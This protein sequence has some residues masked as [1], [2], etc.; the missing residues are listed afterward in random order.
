MDFE[1]NGPFFLTRAKGIIDSSAAAKKQFWQDIE[2]QHTGLPDACGCFVFAIKA[3]RGTL[4][5][6]VGK[7][8]RLS[9][10]QECLSPHKVTHF[11]RAVAGRTSSAPVIYLLPHLT[12][13]GKYK[14]PATAK[15]DHQAVQ[16]LESLL[17]GMAFSKNPDL[18]NIKGTKWLRELMVKGF[19]NSKKAKGGPAKELRA[20]FGI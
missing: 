12:A 5:W 9:F 18:L 14:S 13:G 6:Y 1:V 17:I 3:N 20:V 8:E 16:K 15:A 11:N 2:T 4:P 7:A 19:I 10:K